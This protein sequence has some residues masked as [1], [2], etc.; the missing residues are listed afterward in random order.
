MADV[1]VGRLYQREKAAAKDDL[2]PLLH[3]AARFGE[4]PMQFRPAFDF[5]KLDTP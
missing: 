3:R 1:R 2:D 4:I 5:P